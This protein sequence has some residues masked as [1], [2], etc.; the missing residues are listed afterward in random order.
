MKKTIGKAVRVAGVR[1]SKKPRHTQAEASAIIPSDILGD[2]M[3]Q[4]EID[5]PVV[6]K[7]PDQ[8][9]RSKKMATAVTPTH[10][11]AFNKKPAMAKQSRI[12]QPK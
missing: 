5:S 8:R 7:F 3:D 4:I 11:K 10:D 2:P 9:T 6:P 12:Q 1:V